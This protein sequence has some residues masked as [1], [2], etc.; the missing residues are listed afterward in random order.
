MGCPGFEA[1]TLRARRPALTS[2]GLFPLRTSW[3]QE[4]HLGPARAVLAVCRGAAG[5]LWVDLPA[6]PRQGHTRRGDFLEARVP[7][8]SGWAP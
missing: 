1:R 6:L 8:R 4:Q 5:L 7:T 3:E 2:H